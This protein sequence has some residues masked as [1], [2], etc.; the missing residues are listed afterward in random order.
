M[1][2]VFE[3]SMVDELKYFLGFQ[4]NN[5]EDRIFLSQAKYAKNMVKKFELDTSKSKRTPF[6]THVKVAKDED[7]KSMD[8][9]TYRSI[10]VVGY[11]DADWAGNTE[12]R[13]STSEGLC[14]MDK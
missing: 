10:S 1:E 11:C 13:K 7:G 5:M 4:I 12:D 14:M 3:M 8:I 9:S 2:A 6:A